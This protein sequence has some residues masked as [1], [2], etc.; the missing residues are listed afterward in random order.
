MAGYIPV[1]SSASNDLNRFSWMLK[2]P[3]SLLGNWYST[4]WAGKLFP[5][6]QFSAR[7]KITL[8]FCSVGGKR[9]SN[10]GI[11]DIFGNAGLVPEPVS[12]LYP[13]IVF[14]RFFKALLRKHHLLFDL[15]K[16]HLLFDQAIYPKAELYIP[17]Q[18]AIFNRKDALMAF[19]GVII[20]LSVKP[21]GLISY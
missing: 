2:P 8:S 10:N 14:D 7:K 6:P 1:C 9:L 5:Y 15:R 13:S 16:H 21:S 3:R 20:M 18:L 11:N 17:S 4:C 19:R 12:E